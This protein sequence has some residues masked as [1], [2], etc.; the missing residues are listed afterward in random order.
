MTSEIAEHAESSCDKTSAND[1]R[2]RL[3][4]PGKRTL[5]RPRL[6]GS[7]GARDCEGD[8][9]HCDQNLKIE[10][11]AHVLCLRHEAFLG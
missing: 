11:E 8:V 3:D 2:S 10:I 4:K 1:D 5:N 6:N 9:S 7:G